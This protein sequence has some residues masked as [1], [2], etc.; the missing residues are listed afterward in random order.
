MHAGNRNWGWALTTSATTDQLI[1]KVDNMHT[2]TNQPGGVMIQVLLD[3]LVHLV[4]VPSGDFIP[5][6]WNEVTKLQ[7]FIYS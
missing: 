7:A 6:Y 1:T 5:F 4:T 2:I 3:V